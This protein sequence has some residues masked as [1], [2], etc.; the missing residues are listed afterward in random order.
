MNYFNGL[1]FVIFI[2]LFHFSGLLPQEK[3][4][5]ESEGAGMSTF[6]DCPKQNIYE[7]ICYQKEQS[8]IPKVELMTMLAEIIAYIGENFE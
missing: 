3:Q 1:F 5:P 8:N 7:D 2:A 6:G 4:S